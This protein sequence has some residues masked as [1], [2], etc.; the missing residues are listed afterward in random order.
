VRAKSVSL[1]TGRS[2]W[3][4]AERTTSRRGGS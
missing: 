4:L 3:T 2:P 1:R